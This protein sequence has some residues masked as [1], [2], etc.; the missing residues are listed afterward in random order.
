M[1]WNTTTERRIQQRDRQIDGHGVRHLDKFDR[2]AEAEGHAR[3][4]HRSSMPPV[5]GKRI[6]GAKSNYKKTKVASS[7][8]QNEHRE[9]QLGFGS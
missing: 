2:E 1:A 3:S 8:V 7:H 9:R 4:Q 6:S 5:M